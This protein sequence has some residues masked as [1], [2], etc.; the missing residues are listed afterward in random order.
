MYQ[1]PKEMI[2]LTS[3]EVIAHENSDKCYICKGEFTTSDY[4]AKDHD[5]IQGYYRGAAHNSYN[6]KARVPQFLPIIMRN[7]SG[8]DSHLFIRELGE[9]GKTIDV[10]PEK[11]ERYISF[12]NRVKK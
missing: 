9:D 1:N 2:E 11:S 3:E 10:I 8:H 5:H 4:K 7:L 12:S 6:L